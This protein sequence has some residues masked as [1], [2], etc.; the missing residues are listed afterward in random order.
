[1][2]RN[3]AVFHGCVLFQTEEHLGCVYGNLAAIAYSYA[4]FPKKP[5]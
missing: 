1:M 4:I 3:A 2:I 5:L